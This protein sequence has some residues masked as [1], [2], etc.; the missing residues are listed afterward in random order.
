M[1][2]GSTQYQSQ[3]S[4]T[5]SLWQ[6]DNGKKLWD[7]QGLG[8]S[9]GT[10]GFTPDGKRVASTGFPRGGANKI[11]FWD[12]ATGAEVGA[13]EL[14]LTGTHFAFD[15]SGK[16]LAIALRDTTTMIYSVD[17]ALKSQSK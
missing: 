3:D 9:P 15:R 8:W 4:Y 16:R 10:I 17:A 2:D 7:A 14:P 11:Q 12:S 1:P 6:L 13:I 5:V